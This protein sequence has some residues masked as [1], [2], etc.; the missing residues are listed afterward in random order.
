MKDFYEILGVE[1]TATKAQ[2]KKAYRK[3]AKIHHPDKGGDEDVFKN[4]SKAYEV[5]TDPDKRERYDRGE[6]TDDY[7][8]PNDQAH[9]NLTRIFDM[10]IHGH[11]FMADHTDLIVR[12]KEEINDMTLKMRNDI[13]EIEG[14]IKKLKSILKRLKKADFLKDYARNILSANEARKT[15]IEEAIKVQGLMLE[16]LNISEY[17]FESDT[18]DEWKQL[19]FKYEMF[20]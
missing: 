18:D 19:P 10:V 1:K 16:F 17:D 3:L 7:R 9:D 12:M 5:L 20:T 11:G 14:T 15:Q 13:S 8:S 4:I 6:Y 2:I